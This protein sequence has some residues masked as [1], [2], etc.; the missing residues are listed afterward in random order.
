MVYVCRSLGRSCNGASWTVEESW[1]QKSLDIIWLLC[2]DTLCVRL[3]WLGSASPKWDLQESSWLRRRLAPRADMRSRK[4]LSP[5]RPLGGF[6]FLC[7]T[8]DM[9]LSERQLARARLR[10]ITGEPPSVGSLRPYL[11]IPGPWLA[12]VAR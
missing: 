12:S 2:S 10:S 3:C 4:P 9:T 6:V 5:R 7:H 8:L 11:L 1:S